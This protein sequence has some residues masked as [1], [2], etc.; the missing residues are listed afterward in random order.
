[1][2]KEK[3]TEILDQIYETKKGIEEMSAEALSFAKT[4]AELVKTAEE[5]RQLSSKLTQV[6]DNSNEIRSQVESVAVKDTLQKLDKS[7]EDIQK[8]Y[9]NHLNL[10]KVRDA[11]IQKVYDNHISLLN[12]RDDKFEKFYFEEVTKMKK[13]NKISLLIMGGISLLCSIVALILALIK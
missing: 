3:A 10:L 12:E 2:E 11:E 1:M 5:F 7:I 4:K 9:D 8:G 6:V 13:S